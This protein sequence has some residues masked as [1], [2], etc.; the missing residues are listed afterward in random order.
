MELPAPTEE[1]I[2][3]MDE[4]DHPNMVFGAGDLETDD[5]EADSDDEN[6]GQS[7]VY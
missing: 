3:A 6:G 1:E 4:T 7:A 5:L 2:E